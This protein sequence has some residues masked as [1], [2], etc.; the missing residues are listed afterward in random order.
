VFFKSIVRLGG[1]NDNEI[2]RISSAQNRYILDTLYGRLLDRNAQTASWVDDNYVCYAAKANS[3]VIRADGA[4]NKCTVALND[5][6]NVVGRLNI[7]G[8]MSLNR[9]KI[10]PWI[11]GIETQVPYELACPYTSHIKLSQSEARPR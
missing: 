3:F 1:P 7:D 11:R 9:K 8:T 10:L 6:R 2:T 4:I 5:E